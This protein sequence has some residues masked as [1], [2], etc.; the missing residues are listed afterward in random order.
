MVVHYIVGYATLAISTSH[1]LIQTE[2]HTHSSRSIMKMAIN[3]YIVYTLYLNSVRVSV[4]IYILCFYV[5]C[6]LDLKVQ[7]PVLVR[8]AKVFQLLGFE[9]SPTTPLASRQDEANLWVSLCV[10]WL[11]YSNLCEWRH[12]YQSPGHRK[13]TIKNQTM[14]WHW[15]NLSTTKTYLFMDC[16]K[17]KIKSMML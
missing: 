5:L 4:C 10:S 7:D 12:F 14:Q 1:I 8:S 11:I 3:I 2:K 6:C 17:Y 16:L 9:G 13:Q 15:R